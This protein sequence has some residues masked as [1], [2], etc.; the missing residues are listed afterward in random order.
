MGS[1]LT[2]SSICNIPA[3]TLKG[4][5]EDMLKV[6]TDYLKEGSSI[7][8]LGAGPGRFSAM[9][10]GVGYHVTAGDWNHESFRPKGIQC[11]HVDCD[12]PSSI[13]KTFGDRSYDGIICGDLIEHL[14]N[15]FQFI[16]TVSNLLK[17]STQSNEGGYLFISTPNVVSPQSRVITLVNGNPASFGKGGREIGHI[18]PIFPNSM[19]TAFLCAGLECVERIGIG[20][21]TFFGERSFRGIMLCVLT[22]ILRPIMRKVDGHA[23]ILFIGKRVNERIDCVVNPPGTGHANLYLV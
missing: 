16:A 6:V 3:F 20:E 2:N 7:L 14:K 19:E 10:Q 18:N 4:V 12:E 9:L 11:H 21:S 13:L 22:V 8:E 17:P 23:G 5:H 15:P 1:K